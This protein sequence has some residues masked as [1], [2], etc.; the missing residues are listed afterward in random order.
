[1]ADFISFILALSCIA[2]FCYRLF[3]MKALL[4]K[5][6]DPKLEILNPS[7]SMTLS[8][9]NGVGLGKYGHFR[10]NGNTFATYQFFSFFFFPILPLGCYRIEEFEDDRYKVYGSIQ[11]SWLEILYIYMGW[12]LWMPA[13]FSFFYILFLLGIIV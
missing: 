11:V 1:M 5:K 10:K 2:L 13:I 12:Y 8:R 7:S 4:A 9:I 6:Y 3:F